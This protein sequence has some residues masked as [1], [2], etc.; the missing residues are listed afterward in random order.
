LDLN[1]GD[2]S[3]A[4]VEQVGVFEISLGADSPWYF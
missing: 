4:L 2:V 3:D 1:G